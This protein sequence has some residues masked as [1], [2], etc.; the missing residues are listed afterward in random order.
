MNYTHPQNPIVWIDREEDPDR[1]IKALSDQSV[2]GLDVETT[3]DDPPALCL[4]QLATRETNYLV[5]PLAVAELQ[6]V[7]DLLTDPEII[8]VIH[9]APF[10]KAVFSS[11]GVDIVNIFDTFE[12]SRRL[13]GEMD[14]YAHSLAAVCRRELGLK[15]NKRWQKSNWR[16]RP[17]LPDQLEYAAL[18]AE[19]MMLLYDHFVGQLG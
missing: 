12:I 17:L 10:E 4:I 8:K 1:H 16:R 18:D 6:P 9:Y 14:R 13:R 11:L 7:F 3:L 15:I 2:L 5:D 19:L